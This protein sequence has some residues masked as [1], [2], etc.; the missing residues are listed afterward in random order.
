MLGIRKMR[1]DFLEDLDA[2]FCEKYANY[3]KICM[4]DGY[5]M[6]KMQST[7][8]DDFGRT[9]A[10]TLPAETMRLSLQE[11]KA[12]ILQK[13]KEKMTDKT[14]SFSFRTLSWFHQIENLFSKQ[15]LKKIF[16]T[17]LAHYNLTMEQAFEG[18]DVSK[19]AQR[20]II[21]GK[22]EP[23]KNLIFS[24]AIVN[25]FSLQDTKALLN[26][27]GLRL[28]FTC[29][30]DV[31]FAYLISN[32]IFNADMVASALAEYKISHLFIKG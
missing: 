16:P 25:H 13:L 5:V 22:A 3:D 24:M 11:N 12:E 15:S 14:F 18:L 29:E 8:I 23:T 27:C 30:K 6:P 19:E 26:I 2:Y 32:S 10:Y 20:L 4:I 1:F 21:S 9:Y 17:I 7:R 31:V 28:D